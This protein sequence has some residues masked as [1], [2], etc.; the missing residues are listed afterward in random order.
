VFG[1]VTAIGRSPG[2]R[3]HNRVV[4]LS[5]DPERSAEHR[6]CAICGRH[7]VQVKG[8]VY[9]AEI[10]HAVFFA[11][12]HQH[13]AKEAWI[14][15]ILGTFGDDDTSDHVTFGC[16]VGPVIGQ[17]EPA[18]TL[19]PAAVPY[20]ESALFGVKLSR[21]EALKH[22]RLGEFWL[23]VDFVLTADPDVSAHI[24]GEPAGKTLLQRVRARFGRER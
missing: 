14:D 4:A 6:S 22:A 5:F 23:V 7:Y 21:E 9:Q 19:V 1:S 13:E 10:P 11:A 3:W 2:R 8:F 15:V 12:L 17:T 24:Y 16:R 18:A 20:G